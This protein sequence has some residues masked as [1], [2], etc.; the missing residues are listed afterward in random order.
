MNDVELVCKVV[1]LMG[2]ISLKINS[3]AEECLSVLMKLISCY[4]GT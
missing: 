1:T 4:N 3:V 2:R